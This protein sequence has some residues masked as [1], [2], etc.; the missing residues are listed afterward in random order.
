[1]DARRRVIHIFPF[2]AYL[3]AARPEPHLVLQHLGSREA[4]LELLAALQDAH[5]D[6][7]IRLGIPLPFFCGTAEDA[8][9]RSRHYVGNARRVVFVEHEPF[10]AGVAHA[11]DLTLDRLHRSVADQI[12]RAEPR[13]VDD[14]TPIYELI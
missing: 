1:V 13:A 10:E 4:R 5:S 12:A 11:H 2:E 14:D 8:I 3:G 7:R 6:L 9:L